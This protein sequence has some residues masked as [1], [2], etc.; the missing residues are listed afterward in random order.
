MFF[1]SLIAAFLIGTAVS[2]FSLSNDLTRKVTDRRSLF[3]DLAVLTTGGIVVSRVEPAWA[4]GGATAGKYTTIPIA[5]RRYYGRVQQAV[6]D[7]LLMGPDVVK[8]EAQ[9]ASIQFFFDP[10]GVVVV[11]AKKKDINGQCTKKDG[12]CRGK[13][14]RD[15]RFN[16]MKASMYLLANAFRTDQQKPP[17]R[18]PT[19]K[20]AKA[21]FK[22]MNDMEKLVTKKGKVDSKQ[23]AAVYVA[24][25]D[26]LDQ[27]LDLVELPPTDS[28]HYEQEFDTLV[29][30]SPRIT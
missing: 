9:A 23:V 4:S 13:E 8:G 24:A 25:L 19:V 1:R 21:F 15:S 5:K 22:E 6:H 7:F 28:G 17:D 12:D 14:I 2:G 20:A 26:I 29:G 10:Q 18:L 11:P 3:Q 16:D 27:Y 30:E